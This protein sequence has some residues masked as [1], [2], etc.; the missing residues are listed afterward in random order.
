MCTIKHTRTNNT[1]QHNTR[2]DETFYFLPALVLQHHPHSPSLSLTLT[3]NKYLSQYS[4]QANTCVKMSSNH[5]QQPTT[6][7]KRRRED[8]D[9]DDKNETSVLSSAK[10]TATFTVSPSIQDRDEQQDNDDDD[11]DDDI[12]DDD[13]DDV[14]TSF[15]SVTGST[16]TTSSTT[17]AVGTTPAG[18]IS[19]NST[20]GSTAAKDLYSIDDVNDENDD[21]DDGSTPTTSL[22]HMNK[23]YGA[24]ISRDVLTPDDVMALRQNGL[25][26]TPDDNP[27]YPITN[28]LRKKLKREET[29]RPLEALIIRRATNFLSLETHTHDGFKDAD[30][31]IRSD[32]P[33]YDTIE[34]RWTS[35]LSGMKPTSGLPI[36]LEQEFESN[37]DNTGNR[38]AY[39]RDDDEKIMYDD[40][41]RR[42]L[43]LGLGT[44]FLI[45]SND[46]I[47]PQSVPAVT[48]VGTNGQHLEYFTTFVYAGLR[49]RITERTDEKYAL[50][51]NTNHYKSER[52]TK[53]LAINCPPGP[54]GRN[55]YVGSTSGTSNAFVVACLYE[56]VEN[57]DQKRSQQMETISNLPLG[58]KIWLRHS[59][60]S[61]V[62]T[63]E[64]EDK[65]G[66]ECYNMPTWASVRDYLNKIPST[67]HHRNDKRPKKLK[68]LVGDW[69]LCEIAIKVRRK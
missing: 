50:R 6:T 63:P 53:V 61:S 44:K 49:E 55:Q 25:R 52:S 19:T 51:H 12:D 34:N 38:E 62:T 30:A 42:I 39:G 4:C 37:K 45:C 3:H 48:T 33:S 26:K 41:F 32:S 21:D 2:R 15:V 10:H 31:I 47:D 69:I 46:T 13:D 5:G 17:Q 8:D 66:S 28:N 24:A 7:P 22:T 68:T 60:T 27:N 43:D 65:L 11:D 67:E 40:E 1:T 20:A 54:D 23:R 36:Q 56:G 29:D 18:R 58:T 59:K 35:V 64:P 16:P 9:D 57:P 14:I